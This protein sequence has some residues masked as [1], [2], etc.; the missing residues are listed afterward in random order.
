MAIEHGNGE[1]GVRS[2][3][4]GVSARAHAGRGGVR[5]EARRGTAAKNMELIGD[6]R[7]NWR[8]NAF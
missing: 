4:R 3:L 7:G 6:W 2:L 8:D 1:G 5:E